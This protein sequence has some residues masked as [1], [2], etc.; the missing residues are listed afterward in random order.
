MCMKKIPI[1][2]D[3]DN[4]VF[5]VSDLYLDAWRATRQQQPEKTKGYPTRW[6]FY[7]DPAFPK[8]V[9]DYLLDAFLNGA[10][11]RYSCSEMVAE[12]LNA[13]ICHPQYD[14]FFITDRPDEL[15]SYGQLLRNKIHVA[16]SHLIV[17]H[18]KHKTLAKLGIRIHCDDNP[19][20]LEHLT[21]HFQGTLPVLM[22]NAK[23]L[24]NHY[25]RNRKLDFG[26]QSVPVPMYQNLSQALADF[27]AIVDT[28]MHCLDFEKKER[29]KK[30]IKKIDL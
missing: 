23:T 4:T 11:L 15:D 28:L 3:L 24:Y 29:K 1:S 21:P 7:N 12:R 6:D 5:D 18:E 9:S 14:V 17:S 22:S 2:F 10:L 13:L 27:D 16:E 8:V 25:V 19:L 20:V 26:Q 30:A